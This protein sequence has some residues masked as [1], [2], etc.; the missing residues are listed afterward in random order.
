[1]ALLWR[2]LLACACARAF[3]ALALFALPARAQLQPDAPLHVVSDP[4]VLARFPLAFCLDGT[5]P[6]FY[7]RK[8]TSPDAAN[9]W[10]IHMRGGG[11]CQSVESCAARALTNLGSSAYSTP[12]FNRSRDSDDGLLG[13]NEGAAAEWHMVFTVYC[14]GSS[15]S[16]LRDAPVPVPP[17]QAPAAGAAAAGAAAAGAAA[18]G[19]APAPPSALW[20]RGADVMPAIFAELEV[21]AGLQSRATDVVITGTSAGGLATFVHAP[22]L[23]AL[24]PA[25]ADVVAAPDAGAFVDLADVYGQHSWAASL[26]ASVSLWNASVGAECAAARAP[27]RDAWRCLLP[28]VAYAAAPARPRVFVVQSLNDPTGA[29]IVIRLPC[30]FAAGKCNASMLGQLQ[31]YTDGVAAAVLGAQAGR[32]A[33]AHFLTTCAQHEETCADVDWRGISVGGQTLGETFEL[34]RTRAGPAAG[35]SRRDVPWPGDASCS[36]GAVH[37]GC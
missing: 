27:T 37:G 36:P 1:M 32:A 10:R 31:R 14:D 15:Y 3:A 4:G 19:A 12:F 9:K 20:F 24:L 29:G 30:S 34:W 23:A 5:R 18:A 16:G 2:P 35:W 28:E 6:A 11:W 22:A 33:D 17:S 13:P 26:E 7:W 21:L 25:A 8:A